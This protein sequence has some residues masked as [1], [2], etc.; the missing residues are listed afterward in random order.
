MFIEQFT[1]EAGG[2]FATLSGSDADDRMIHPDLEICDQLQCQNRQDVATACDASTFTC[3]HDCGC[4]RTSHIGVCITLGNRVHRRIA[5]D[6]VSC[7]HCAQTARLP[8]CIRH[9]SALDACNARP[10]F[11]P[12]PSAQQL[13]GAHPQNTALG[14][15]LRRAALPAPFCSGSAHRRSRCHQH[16]APHPLPH[17]P[18]ERAPPQR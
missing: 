10:A 9:A 13:S 8:A 17:P 2:K 1:Q 15:P 7:V 14:A 5:S 11:K 3:A 16:L 12:P 4:R 18:K 6:H